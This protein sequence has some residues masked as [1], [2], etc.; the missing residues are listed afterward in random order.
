MRD[1]LP[2]YQ[3][4][5]PKLMHA[6]SSG[7]DG[8]EARRSPEAAKA[9]ASQGTHAGYTKPPL[10]V[11][12]DLRVF[13]ADDVSTEADSQCSWEETASDEGGWAKVARAVDHVEDDTDTVKAMTKAQRMK[14]KR[15]QRRRRINTA[16]SSRTSMTVMRSLAP[17]GSARTRSWCANSPICTAVWRSWTR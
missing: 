13:D 17:T 16:S 12:F 5:E 15:Q 14:L 11:P 3:R 4:V 10:Y 6:C 9:S 2:I 7:N 8:P 1:F